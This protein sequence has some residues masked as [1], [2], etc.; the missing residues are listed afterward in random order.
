MKIEGDLNIY[1]TAVWKDRFL[2]AAN[3]LDSVELDLTQVSEF[4]SSG[5]QLL[6]LLK[7]E[8]TTKRK[9]LVLLSP[10]ATVMDVLK[11][12]RVTDDFNIISDL[13]MESHA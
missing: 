4:D 10:S 1:T 12:C 3:T 13:A 2:E 7:R 9:P 11:L 6:F 8:T 5:L